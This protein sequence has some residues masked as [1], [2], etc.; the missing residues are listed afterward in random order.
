MQIAFYD[1]NKYKQNSSCVEYQSE[2]DKLIFI[3]RRKKNTRK[4]LTM[5][6]LRAIIMSSSRIQSFPCNAFSQTIHGDLTYS[7]QSIFNEDHCFA[8]IKLHVLASKEIFYTRPR[9]ERISNILK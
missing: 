3:Q 8:N 2:F 4:N 6:R 1:L 5:Y 7:Q 9:L